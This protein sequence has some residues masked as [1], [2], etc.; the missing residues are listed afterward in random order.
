MLLD[1]SLKFNPETQARQ[2]AASALVE[3]SEQLAREQNI[4]EATD[5]F[6]RALLLDPSLDFNP[7]TKAQQIAASALVKQAQNLVQEGKVQEA[8]AAYVEAQKLDPTIEIDRYSWGIIC[9]FGSLHSSAKD[10]MFACEKAVELAPD[11][12]NIRDS[13][14]LARALTGNTQGAIEDFQAYIVWSGDEEAKAQRQRWIDAL[15]AGENP[16][17]EEEIQRLLNED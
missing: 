9:W 2:I 6:Q 3:Q 8:I 15:K 12:G 13:R 14:G 17:T 11:N 5:M 7:E 10:V 16:F 4:K 1:P